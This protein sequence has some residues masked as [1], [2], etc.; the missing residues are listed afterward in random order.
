VLGKGTRLTKQHILLFHAI[1]S[2]FFAAPELERSRGGAHKER[3]TF[4]SAGTKSMALARREMEDIRTFFVN[5]RVRRMVTSLRSRDDDD[6]V[7]VIDVAYWV[8]G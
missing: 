7:E 4:N 1:L 2:P 6:P 5:E 8:K 3:K